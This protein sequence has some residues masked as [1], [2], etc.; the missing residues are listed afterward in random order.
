MNTQEHNRSQWARDKKRD[1]LIKTLSRTKRKDYENYIINAIFHKLGRLDIQPVTQQYI[2]RSDGKHALVD[3]YF[4]ALNYGVECDEA[5]HVNNQKQDAVRVL[6]MEDMLNE[7]AETSNFILRR[8]AAYEQIESIDAQI[9]DI[10]SEINDLIK[11]RKIAAW[12]P[13][14]D[15]ADIAIKNGGLKV[16]DNLRFDTIA[17]VA[18]CFGKSYKVMQTSYFNI[19]ND[20]YLWCPKLA[21]IEE[22]K[23]KPV[24][25]GW[26]NILSDDWESIRESNDGTRP[27]NAVG[28]SSKRFTFAKSKDVL[29]RNQYRF[30]GVFEFSKEF[31][32][33]AENVYK[34]ISTFVD[35]KPW[36]Q[37]S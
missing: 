14:V 11:E 28:R 31:S 4:P 10:V 19:Q 18:H 29:G 13:Y 20:T 7:V 22:G 34:R 2:R 21:T 30:I 26:I 33:N 5:Y 9:I 16:E 17:S 8:V 27:L 23:S 6:T 12:D 36:L 32:T 25:S 15:P 24:S 35:L 37:K 1:Y 3:L